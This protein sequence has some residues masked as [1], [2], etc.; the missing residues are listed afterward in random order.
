MF[1]RLPEIFKMNPDGTGVK[2][3]AFNGAP[4]VSPHSVLLMRT[5]SDEFW[6]NR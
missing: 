1:L 4:P 2:Q 5:A 3:L 6:M